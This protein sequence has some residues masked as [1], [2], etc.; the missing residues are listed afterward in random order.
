MKAF[1]RFRLL[2]R[3]DGTPLRVA[4]FEPEH[5]IVDAVAPFFVK[6]FANMRW[7]IL[8]PKGCAH[9]LP[10]SD[11]LPYGRLHIGPAADAIRLPRR[12]VAKPW[13]TYYASTFNPASEAAHHATCR[14]VIGKTCQKPH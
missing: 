14:A 3:E 11:D 1:V 10:A 5:Y 9:W 6:R 12:T 7:S 13:L 4:W 2:T 8:T